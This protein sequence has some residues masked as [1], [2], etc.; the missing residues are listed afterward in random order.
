M[1]WHLCR[2]MAKANFRLDLNFGQI[3]KH[4]PVLRMLS[5]RRP[6][7][8]ND[9]LRRASSCAFLCWKFLK[10][11]LY[12]CRVCIKSPHSVKSAAT[13]MPGG[14]FFLWSGTGAAFHS[15]RKNLGTSLAVQWL[16]LLKAGGAGLIPGW[17]AKIPHASWLKNQ[18]IKQKQCCNKFN[19]L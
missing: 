12:L 1:A 3:L 7:R 14:F 2:V 15:K 16:S 11:A 18:N 6:P 10:C 8:T 9:S 13:S 19:R 5:P 17:G 4:T